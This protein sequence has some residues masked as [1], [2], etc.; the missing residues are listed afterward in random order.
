MQ[1]TN[2]NFNQQNEQ[3]LNNILAKSTLV[4]GVSEK[5]RNQFFKSIYKQI[6]ELKQHILAEG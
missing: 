6:D 4:S 1:T 5:Q 3:W 2:A